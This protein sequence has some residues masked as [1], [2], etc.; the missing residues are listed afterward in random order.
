[1]TQITDHI[2]NLV[3][4]ITQQPPETRIRTAV[5]KMVNAY[6]SAVQGLSKR[7]G[8]EHLQSLTSASLQ[9]TTFMHQIDRSATEKYIMMVSPDGSLEVFD[10]LNNQTQ[11]VTVEGSAETYLASSD[12][13]VYLRAVTGGDTTFIAN[14]AKTVALAAKPE[15]LLQNPA[16]RSQIFLPLRDDLSRDSTSSSNAREG[17]RLS[18]SLEFQQTYNGELYKH[19]VVMQEDNYD[20]AGN[21]ITDSFDGYDNNYTPV[22]ERFVNTND[23]TTIP[24]IVG[25]VQGTKPSDSIQIEFDEVTWSLTITCTDSSTE[26]TVV[27][28]QYLGYDRDYT[29]EVKFAT[30]SVADFEDL[31]D[32]G[33]DNN[34]VK[35][36]GNADKVTD[37]YYVRWNG[38]AWV[39]ALGYNEQEA[40]DAD[41]MPHVLEKTDTGWTLRP[42]VWEQRLVG[43]YDVNETPSFVG[44]S[45]SDLFFF[46]GRFGVC[47]GESIVM[48]E[49]NHF[50]NFYRTTCVQLED[51]ERIDVQLRFGRVEIPH[52]AI[53]VQDELMLFSDKGQF[54]MGAG[55]QALSPKT[56][57]VKQVGDFLTN[58]TVKPYSLGYTAFF[59]SEVGGYTLAREFY[60]GS[61]TDDRL[62]SSDLTIQCTQYIPG[63][64]RYISASRDHKILFVLTRDEP[65][66]IYV[67]KFE[68]DGQSKV[69]SAWCKW[70]LAIGNIE[71]LTVM[72]SY[73]Y[74]VSTL[75]SQRELTRIDIRDQQDLPGNELLRL[76][77]QSIPSPV[78]YANGISGDG[79]AETLLNLPYDGTDVTEVWDL[80]SGYTV[81]VDRY[82]EGGN[83]FVKGDFRDKVNSGYVVVGIPY[84][85]DVKLSTLYMKAPKKP[86][87]EILVTDGRLTIQYVN[88]AYTDTASFNVEVNNRGRDA[89]VHYAGPK[90]GH[91]TVNY[92]EVPKTSGALRVPVRSKN[93]NTEISI[94]N[95]DPFG[96]TILHVDWFGKHVA[97]AR[98]V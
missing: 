84:E 85:M 28:V 2:P 35:V 70:D 33:S 26:F 56:V 51:D 93:E 77:M 90:A 69:Q 19:T 95:P 68:Y 11:T 89:V 58:A 48:S 87:G 8:A 9:A 20:E 66:C 45:I 10:V 31:P 54:S 29:D 97:N 59:T 30:T 23:N 80:T 94:K 65:N 64:A 86:Q 18:I 32:K 40:L 41:T 71:S 57:A 13:S 17:L 27:D 50:E 61:A 91:V 12:P 1:M 74:C 98:R 15:E 82:T 38:S 83:L 44:Q 42:Y 22:G 78:Y 24:W 39:E 4:G 37:D 21:S 16:T 53:V 73:L 79:E 60:L 55:G 46:Q 81:P 96:C 3:G 47:S 6:P 92:G 43:D 14:R 52:S 7:R 75:G 34:I 36:I 49:V 72:G 67:Y 25:G 5:D 76:D 88:V 62:Q 63:N